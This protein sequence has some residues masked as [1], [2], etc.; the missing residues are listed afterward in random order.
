M[1][2]LR[3]ALPILVALALAPRS[4]WAH[5]GGEHVTSASLWA[6]WNWG[7]LALFALASVVYAGGVVRLRRRSRNSFT[8]QVTAF[9]AGMV[10]LAAALGSPIE[11]LADQLFTLHMVQHLLLVVVAAPLLVWGL[12]PALLAWSL[13]DVARRPLL[14]EAHRQRG[15][16]RMWSLLTLPWLAWGVYAAALWIW[17]APALYQAALDY[18]WVHIL[19]HLCL[20]ATSLLLWWVTLRTLPRRGQVGM[21]I[22]LGLTTAVHSGL[23]GSLLTFGAEPWVPRYIFTAPQWGLSALADQQLAGVIMWVP[24]GVV[25]LGVA[26][27]QLGTL[28]AEPGAQTAA[29]RVAAH[30]ANG[31]R[32]ATAI[33]RETEAGL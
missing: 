28:L 22:L 12:S 21:A 6:H 15:L 13:P 4:A 24:S 2:S 32:I 1:K 5:G 23:L 14:V 11:A 33:K 18:E 29:G 26:L 31:G 8:L 10:A 19:E 17:H 3:R 27:W 30:P 25:Y 7:T 16:V 9:A 20:F